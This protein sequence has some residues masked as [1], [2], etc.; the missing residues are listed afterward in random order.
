MPNHQVSNSGKLNME[1]IKVHQMHMMKSIDSMAVNISKLTDTLII[2]NERQVR[3]DAVLDGVLECQRELRRDIDDNA[4]RIYV[5]EL[6][7][8]RENAV[9]SERGK[10]KSF[11]AN[12]WFNLITLFIMIWP[13]MYGLIKL[14]EKYNV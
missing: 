1:Q 13:I 10:V 5:L 6:A 4:E 9:N 14:W 3:H 8:E 7:A 11:F 12:N 2:S